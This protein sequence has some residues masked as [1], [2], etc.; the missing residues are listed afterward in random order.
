MPNLEGCA[1]RPL[2]PA[3]LRLEDR[4]ILSRL[5]G[6][7]EELNRALEGYR[8][9]ECMKVL[10][11]FMWD[12]YC[13]SYI[14]MTKP[15][16]SGDDRAAAQQVLAYVLDQLLRMLHPFIPFVTEAIWQRLNEAAPQRGL[17]T[18]AAGEKAITIAAWPTVDAALRNEQVEAEM[19]A[20]Q[21]VIK[22]VR[23][24]RTEVNDYRS[25]N[26]QPS[27]RTLPRA[28]VRADAVTCGSIRTY[29][30]FVQ[31]L[32]GCEVLEAGPDM[33]KP[34]GACSRIEG[35]LQ[36]FVPVADLIDLA[37]VRKTEEAKL[38]ELRAAKQRA[39]KQLANE[40][41]VQRADPA[42]VAQARQRAA[43]LSSQILL[44]EQHLA[45]LG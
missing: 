34:H 13:S 31:P 4:W 35:N 20:L 22:A 30:T 1:P 26:K 27:I 29:G 3:A 21:A 15:R 12:E 5:T 10:Y 45:D 24:I 28:M 25:R 8:F 14:E 9:S 43:D 23:E 11:R 16:L 41:F 36:V 33:A 7:L 18:I 2:D 6:C 44:I 37:A 42:V 32:A 38:A 19:A 39:E 40:S 17:R